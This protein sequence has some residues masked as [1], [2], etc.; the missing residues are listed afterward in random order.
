MNDT[1]AKD[2]CARNVICTTT[3][4]NLLQQDGEYSPGTDS[5]SEQQALLLI[6]PKRTPLP[7]KQLAVVCLCR[8]A[9]PIA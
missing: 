7:K 9:Q 8:L 5:N 1:S 2:A 4:G 6:K 3:D